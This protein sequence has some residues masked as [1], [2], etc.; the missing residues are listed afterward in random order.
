MRNQ[1]HPEPVCYLKYEMERCQPQPGAISSS[2][3]YYDCRDNANC[4][5]S[6]VRIRDQ[7]MGQ[8]M[9]QELDFK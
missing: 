6:Y 5:G 8:I 9:G 7:N 3:M 2:K 1:P 4:E